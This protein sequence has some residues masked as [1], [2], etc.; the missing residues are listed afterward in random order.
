MT[1][2]PLQ[3]VSWERMARA[4]ERVRERLLRSTAALNAAEIP[5]AVAGGHAVAAWVT[6][7]DVG[8]L[9]NCPDVDDIARQCEYER[10][11]HVPTKAGFAYARVNGSQALLE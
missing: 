2:V 1:A 4:V 5:Y 8:G 9:R 3:P 7:A 10:A 11:R 6:T